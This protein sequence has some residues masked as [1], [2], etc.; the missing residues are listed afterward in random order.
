NLSDAFALIMA[1]LFGQYGLIFLDSDDAL[2]RRVESS[3][4]QKL[5]AHNAKL[6]QAL[7]PGQAAMLAHGY[8]PLAE[9]RENNA[10][11]FWLEDGERIL[12]TRSSNEVYTDRSG[13]LRFSRDELIEWANKHPERFSNNVFTRPLMQEYVLPVLATVLGPGEIAYWGLTKDAFRTFGMRM[14]IIAP[15]LEFTLVEPAVKKQMDKLGLSIHDAVFH[16][17]EKKGA[18]LKEQGVLEIEEHFAAVRAQFE[19]FYAPT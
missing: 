1:K 19:Q 17:E 15:R 4:F 14:P 7:H 13:Q 12:L 6:D 8:E 9:V 10:N 2:L 5:I 11:L 16:L 3:F 18:W